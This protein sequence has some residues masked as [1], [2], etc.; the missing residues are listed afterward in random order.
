[1]KIGVIGL[2]RMGSG[3]SKRLKENGF[4]V[5][6]Y[7]VYNSRSRELQVNNIIDK[8]SMT[9]EDL[10]SDVEQ[11][12]PWEMGLPRIILILVPAENVQETLNELIKYC[13]KGDIIVDM[14]NSNFKDSR[15]R[16]IEL[17][18]KDIE[19]I[20]CGTSG[21]VHG[22]ENGYCLM[23][24]GN[25]RAVSICSPIFKTLSPGLSNIPRTNPDESHFNAEYGFLYCGESGAGHFVKMVHNGIEY[26]I[27]QAYAEGFNLLR[28]ANGGK[29]YI[30]TG[31]A[32]IAPMEDPE[33]YCYDF[34]I[35]EIAEVW[36]RGSIIKSYL[37]DLTAK[38]LNKEGDTLDKFSGSVSD[39]GEARWFVKAAVDLG[40]P[41]PVVTTS[42][43]Q[44]FNSRFI[45]D[46]AKKILNS[47]RFAFGGHQVQSQ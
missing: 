45:G 16:A 15:K 44:R 24:G 3:I 2:G 29:K 21:G 40:V 17:A 18:K 22:V 6:G 41:T 14:G 7:D 25:A 33:S 9:I 4:R 12:G 19:F 34:K 36:R 37:L 11:K 1:M 20:D 30:T 47:M 23:I 42:L 26:G 28:E 27:M 38:V 10:M 31:S 39:S 43:Y 13:S 8:A 46:Y 32:E 5:R 35:K